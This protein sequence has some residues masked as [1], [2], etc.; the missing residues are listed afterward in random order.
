MSLKRKKKKVQKTYGG[1]DDFRKDPRKP[2]SCNAKEVQA[3][4]SR[5]KDSVLKQW[6]W[7]RNNEG[8]F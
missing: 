3:S 1:V 2:T 7:D 4:G 6:P 5:R 8:N